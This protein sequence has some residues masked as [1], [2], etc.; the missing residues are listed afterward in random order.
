MKS[1][2]KRFSPEWWEWMTMPEPN[3]GCILWLGCVCE[4]GYGRLSYAKG[5]PVL[6]HRAAYECAYGPIEGRRH[7]L[8]RCDT[9]SCVNP[10]HLFIGSQEDN[11]RDMFA[12]GRARPYGSGN[13]RLEILRNVVSAPVA[14]RELASEDSNANVRIVDPIHHI[15]TTP[16]A[17]GWRHVTGVPATRPTYAMVLVERPHGRTPEP[18]S[19]ADDGY[20]A[21]ATLAPCWRRVSAPETEGAR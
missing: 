21:V 3:T 8:H 13:P 19:R 4:R 18:S 2:F 6:A 10:D 1:T 20:P 9:P 16:M 15:R 11:M 14:V 12:K 5:S 17:S 7:V